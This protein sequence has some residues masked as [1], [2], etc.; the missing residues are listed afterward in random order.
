[1]KPLIDKKQCPCCGE[2]FIWVFLTPDYPFIQMQKMF[3]R[4]DFINHQFEC[5]FSHYKTE[6]RKVK[7]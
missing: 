2:V 3:K 6:E 4:I 7:I 5:S 1:M